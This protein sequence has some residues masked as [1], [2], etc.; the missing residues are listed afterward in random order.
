MEEL[1]GKQLGSYQV[2]APLGEGGMAA[3]YKAYQPGMERYVALKIL[4][5][6]F[7]NDPQFA[8]RFDQEAKVLAK[9]QHPHILPVFDFGQADG[10]TY[11]V[12][13]FL[14]SGD[15]TDL[16]AGQSL[17]LGQIRR[18]ISQ[19]GDALDYAHSRGLI[20]RDVKPSN[21]L[22]DERGNCLLTDFGIAKIVEGSS[23]LTVTG[24]IIGTPAYMSPEQGMGEKV[25]GRSD[26]YALGIM[27]YEMATG[28]VPYQAE[29]PMAVMIKHLNDPLPPPRRLNPALPEAV[30]QVILKALAKQPQDRYATAGEMVRALQAAIPEIIADEKT[31][32]NEPATLLSAEPAL[33]TVKPEAAQTS[34]VRGSAPANLLWLLAAAAAIVVIGGLIFLAVGGNGQ[35]GPTATPP[36]TSQVEAGPGP[37]TEAIATADTPSTPQPSSASAHLAS[38]DNFDDTAFDGSWNSDLWQPDSDEPCQVAQQDGALI[39]KAP[40][41]T[42]EAISCA[43]TI[44]QPD[45]VSADALGVVEA[46]LQIADDL[47]GEQVNQGIG[48]G[49]EDLPSGDWFAFCGLAAHLDS[50]EA[51]FEVANYGT[52]ASPDISQ[53]IPAAFD[54]WHTFRMEVTPDPLTLACFVDDTLIG[55][56]TP[57]DA[58][59]LRQARFHRTLDSYREAGSTATTYADDVRLSGDLAAL[60]DDFEAPAFEG[61]LNPELWEPWETIDNCQAAQEEGALRFSCTQPD[62]SGLNALRYQGAAFGQISFV[63]AR[64]KLDSEMQAERGAV[65]L[66]LASSQDRWAECSLYGGPEQAQAQLSCGVASDRNGTFM[67]EYNVAGPA[68][69]YDAWRVVRIEMNPESGEFAFFVGGQPIGAHTPAEA[70]AMKMAQFDAELQVYL[71]D[72]SLVTGYFDDVRIGRAEP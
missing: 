60:Y 45:Q 2:V 28:R 33:A 22:L 47:T 61:Q 49:T 20:H 27:L 32:E 54:R 55:S 19:V 59:A 18:L 71:E 53:G 9:L 57:A 43:L 68:T 37:P 36:P 48:I 8:A 12:M 21:V 15:L 7:A 51:Y 25:D 39:F 62:G 29:T 6:H 24:G 44:N 17:P 63:E 23:K 34:A 70:E 31:P 4:P 65:T 13:P 3:V 66:L 50:I 16:L 26:I 52:G 5:R 10:Y 46:R 41:Q 42:E 69:S 14:Q 72:G 11:I 35:S 30:E 1:T 67:E 40:A 38:Y 56:V 58:P 64:L